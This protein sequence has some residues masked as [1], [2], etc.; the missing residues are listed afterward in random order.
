LL[1][2]TVEYALR[3]SVYLAA[4]KLDARTTDQI[5]QVTLVPAAY[6]SKV[7]QSLSRA[8]IVR[9]QRGVKGGFQLAKSPDQ[10][11]I[12]DIMRAVDPTKRTQTLPQNGAEESAVLR[13]LHQRLELIIGSVNETFRQTTLASLVADASNTSP[14]T[15]YN[16]TNGQHQ[17]DEL[18]SPP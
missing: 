8:G 16:G 15:T 2:Q 9:S 5:A 10:I 3:A 1:S 12:F 6:L 18:H 4:I 13:V 14:P 11:S 17:L 7:L